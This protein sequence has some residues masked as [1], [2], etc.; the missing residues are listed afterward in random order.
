MYIG[1][2][3]RVH[4]D[5]CIL[6]IRQM[7][8]SPFTFIF[9]PQILHVQLILLAIWVT[10]TCKRPSPKSSYTYCILRIPRELRARRSYLT[11]LIKLPELQLS[12]RL[13][14]IS[15]A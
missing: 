1:Q 4:F 14:G 8:Y 5:Q 3:S 7:G 9:L 6:H 12:L 11:Y 10:T 2:W 13:S 15:L